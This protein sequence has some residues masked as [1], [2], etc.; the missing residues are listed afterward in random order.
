MKV[1]V[2][3]DEWDDALQ[4]CSAS[5]MYISSGAF[6][7]NA[8]SLAGGCISLKTG[9]GEVYPVEG[10]PFMAWYKEHGEGIAEKDLWNK[11]KESL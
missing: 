6:N 10:S 1:L 11:Y 8:R 9:Q 7:Y 4:A 3:E 2:T 5:E